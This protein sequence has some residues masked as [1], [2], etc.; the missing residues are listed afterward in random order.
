ML[1][2]DGPLGAEFFGEFVKADGGEGNG[3]LMV[4]EGLEALGFELFEE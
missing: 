1:L 3:E 4:G 2:F